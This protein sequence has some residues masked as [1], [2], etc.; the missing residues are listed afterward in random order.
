MGKEGFWSDVFLNLKECLRS[1]LL[2]A[3]HRFLFA[4]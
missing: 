1:V 2:D 4:P 3:L